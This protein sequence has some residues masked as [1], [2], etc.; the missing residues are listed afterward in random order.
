VGLS[1]PPEGGGSYFLIV[2]AANTS[3]LAANIRVTPAKA[4]VQFSFARP[5]RAGFR[6]S[7]E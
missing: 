1:F 2:P 3:I 4:G 6:L 5:A 7:R